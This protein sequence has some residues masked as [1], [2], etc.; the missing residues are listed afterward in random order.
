MIYDE[1]N[2]ICDDFLTGV[3]QRPKSGQVYRHRPL[4]GIV[5]R[6][7]PP[8][9]KNKRTDIY[10]AFKKPQRPNDKVKVSRPNLGTVFTLKGHRPVSSNA[11]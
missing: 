9:P 10:K 4:S 1:E 3:R 11:I 8:L 7:K 5:T 6:I 2:L